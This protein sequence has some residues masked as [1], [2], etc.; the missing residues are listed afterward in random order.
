MTKKI[1][2]IIPEKDYKKKLRI[3]ME[4]WLFFEGDI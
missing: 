4:E 1:L 2:D 3:L